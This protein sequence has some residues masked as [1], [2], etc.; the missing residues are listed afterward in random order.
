MKPGDGKVVALVLV[1]VLVLGWAAASAGLN[2][3]PRYG[4]YR[5]PGDRNAYV[6]MGGRIGDGG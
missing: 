5:T 6:Q 4:G 3:N 2:G 1:L